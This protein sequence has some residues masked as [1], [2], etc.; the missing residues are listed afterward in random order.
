MKFRED[1]R[2]VNADLI[3]A[4]DTMSASPESFL[5]GPSKFTNLGQK[6]NKT[7]NASPEFDFFAFLFVS[8]FFFALV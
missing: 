2:K 3:K 8:F 5:S 7:A 4:R 1:I 6:P